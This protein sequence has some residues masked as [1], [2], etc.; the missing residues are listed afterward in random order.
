VAPISL[1]EL[2]P[3]VLYEF[4]HLFCSQI[5]IVIVSSAARTVLIVLGR[6]SVNN[7]IDESFQLRMGAFFLKGV[8]F[9]K[10]SYKSAIRAD[11]AFNLRGK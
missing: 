11:R 8:T 9:L 10:L 1:D 3:H 6:V 5:I 7:C 2:L 4:A